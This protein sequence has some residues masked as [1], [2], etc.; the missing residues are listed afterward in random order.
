MGVCVVDRGRYYN[1]TH[2]TLASL[3]FTGNSIFSPRNIGGLATRFY[4]IVAKRPLDFP[5]RLL[6]S[7]TTTIKSL[8]FY[9]QWNVK[10]QKFYQIFI[11]ILSKENSWVRLSY[12]GLVDEPPLSGAFQCSGIKCSHRVSCK[13]SWN[14]Y[15]ELWIV[16][17]CELRNWFLYRE[18]KSVNRTWTQRICGNFVV[19]S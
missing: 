10:I 1:P 14:L 9:T 4:F 8:H 18:F 15:C 5:S 17:N 13:K 2:R 7:H 3:Q 19:T 11:Q 6:G 16:G 12:P